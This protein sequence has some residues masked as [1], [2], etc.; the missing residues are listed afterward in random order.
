MRTSLVT[1]KF[2]PLVFERISD[3]RLPVEVDGLTPESLVGKS[4]VRIAKQ[5]IWLGRRQVEVG[6][7]FSVS[8]SSVSFRDGDTCVFQGDLES[9][10]G[11]GTGMTRGQIVVEGSVGRRVGHRMSGG[12]IKVC[13]DV[14]DFAGMAMSGGLIRIEG[15]AGDG[16]GSSES[17]SKFGMNRGTILVG[18][19]A[20]RGV[21]QAMRRGTIAVA[22]DAGRLCGWEMLAGSILVFGK[23][24]R[25]YGAGMIRGSIVLAGSVSIPPPP[26]F[27][28]GGRYSGN[29]LRL[30]SNW[31]LNLDFQPAETL[32]DWEGQMF[33]GDCLRGGR[34][35][36]ILSCSS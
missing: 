19:N 16:L 14:S 8:G 7:L 29:L 23:C 13:G 35:E 34:G 21:G 10:H 17:G 9:V 2:M 15:N 4:A 33:H 11:I 26:I 5:K 18:G 1:E 30:L 22:G 6:E 36:L 28:R 24:D 25:D 32:K 3:S 20:G 27:S 12:E 31:L